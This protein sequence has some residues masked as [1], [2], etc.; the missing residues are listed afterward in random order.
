MHKQVGCVQGVFALVYG[1]WCSC[2]VSL[3]AVWN[4]VGRYYIWR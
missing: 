3:V 4:A 2:S 1:V